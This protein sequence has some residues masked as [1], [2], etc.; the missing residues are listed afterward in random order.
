NK[1]LEDL[2]GAGREFIMGRNAL[3][4]PIRVPDFEGHAKRSLSGERTSSR[5]F[6]LTRKGH[7]PRWC[8]ARFSPLRDTDG[9]VSGVVIA[10]TDVTQRKNLEDEA[11][12][13]EETLR[14]VLD[15]MGDALT[16]TDLEGTI[17]EVNREFTEFTGYTKREVRGTT[18]PYPWLLEEE[19]SRFVR[20]IAELREKGALRDYDMH[21]KRNDGREVAISLNT[22]LLRNYQ[23]EPVA[24]LNLARDI[25]ERKRMSTELTSKTLQVEMLNRI[26]SKANSTVDFAGV[27]EV[28][29]QEVGPLVPFD[30]LNVGLLSDDRSRM[31]LHACMSPIDKTLPAGTTIP[32]GE[33]VS[34]LAIREGKA[35]IVGDLLDHKGLPPDNI[36]ARQGFRS[37]MTVPIF[38]N[39]QLLGTLNVAGTSQN[40]YAEKD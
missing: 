12:E 22:T 10:I 39:E 11:R 18:F 28:I 14:H 25:T 23:G 8:W 33:S 27:F 3:E 1:A 31:T 35:V 20:W 34:S 5:D 6:E 7:P 32:V 40:L 16:I 37:Q 24:M 36:G 30:Q 9:T 15:A 13:S 26:I 2:T 29:A 19:M 38:F 21:W 4:G 17:W